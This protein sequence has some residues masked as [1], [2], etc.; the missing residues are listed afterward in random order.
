MWETGKGLGQSV[1][2]RVGERWGEK[3]QKVAR[4]PPR[5][6]PPTRGQVGVEI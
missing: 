3:W 4:D 5:I 2:G 1:H 6:V